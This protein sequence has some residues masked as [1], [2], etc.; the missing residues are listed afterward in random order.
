VLQTPVTRQAR[1]A[2][3]F[4]FR[5]LGPL[6]V[7]VGG[8][9]HPLGR[10][11]LKELVLALLVD[12][13]APVS[14]DRLMD[15]LW[16]DWALA[17]GKAAV[18]NLVGALRRRL[19]EVAPDVQP[20]LLMT[21]PSGYALCVRPEQV[22]A[23]RFE[24]LRAE[25]AAALQAG[26]ADEAASRFEAALAL[27]RGAPLEDAAGKSFAR[28]P[29]AR[30]EELRRTVEED[31][32]SA[33]LR[34]D[35]PDEAARRL[36]GLVAAEPLRERRWELYM[37]AL[38]RAGPAARRPRRLP[39][40]PGAPA[41]RSRCGPWPGAPVVARGRAAARAGVA[42]A[43]RP[44]SRDPRPA[45]PASTARA[46]ELA[47]RARRGGRRG[48][49]A[50]RAGS[51]RHAHRAGRRRQDAR[52]DRRGAGADRRVPRWHRVRPARSAPR[53]HGGAPEAI[54]RQ[55]GD[56]PVLVVLDMIEHLPGARSAV[57]ALL[58]ASRSPLRLGGERRYPVGALAVPAAGVTAPEPIATN[59]SVALFVERARAHD[60]SFTL[61]AATVAAWCR[62]LGGLPLAIEL[63][64]ARVGEAGGALDAALPDLDDLS[65]SPLDVPQRQRSLRATLDWSVSRLSDDAQRLFRRLSVFRGMPDLAAVTAVGADV[66]PALDELVRASLAMP[67]T[68][69]GARRITML[70]MVCAYA[71][72]AP[73]RRGGSGAAAAR[74][75]LPAGRRGGAHR[76]VRLGVARRPRSRRER[77][78]HRPAV[79]A[80]RGRARAGRSRRGRDVPLVAR[81]GRCR[82]RE[83]RDDDG[84]RRGRRR[85]APR[86]RGGTAHVHR[87][88][89]R[90]TG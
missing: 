5:V 13:G 17:S 67:Q 36:E 32:A 10:R 63:A 2:S 25:G 43:C 87:L 12:L 83:A 27:W 73:G 34:R 79:P 81:T 9:P 41:R 4:E 78:A 40:G 60:P 82:R 1:T 8:R 35:L 19:A 28:V 44:G 31:L 80:G 71:R 33:N 65:T 20:R 38:Y 21:E 11:R 85:A 68:E 14:T 18:Q 70:D 6:Q 7:L 22:D 90:G 3:D 24:A 52:G 86:P 75:A 62:H 50:P 48:Q 37:L 56:E 49:P 58:A 72:A 55:L 57:A 66:A 46:G 59:P 30:L 61:D 47:R 26:D 77:P 29:T 42:R 15:A 76:G 45:G 88:V 64:A 69:A 51:A 84:P 89:L 16:E 53:P 23:H 54:T 39:R 74:R